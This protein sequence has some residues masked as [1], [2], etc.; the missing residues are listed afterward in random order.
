VIS[1][2]K[3]GRRKWGPQ[4]EQ[5]AAFHANLHTIQNDAGKG[6]KR[7]RAERVKRAFTRYLDDGG[8]RRV[9][10]KGHENIAKR[11]VVHVA[12]FNLGLLMRKLIGA[13]TPRAW[14]DRAAHLH[15]SKVHLYFAHLSYLM[16]ILGRS[17]RNPHSFADDCPT[18]QY[19]LQHSLQ[20]PQV[21]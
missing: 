14:A 3:A 21:A 6:W 20:L 15:A 18:L 9:W 7:K 10:L 11:L 5:Q 2:P 4:R 8:M 16:I 17:L 1:E 19:S 13:G 12:G